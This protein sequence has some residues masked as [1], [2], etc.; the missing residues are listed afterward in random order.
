VHLSTST[1]DH[2][3][4]I[5]FFFLAAWAVSR[6]AG[7]LFGLRHALAVRR[8]GGDPGAADRVFRS[9]RQETAISLGQ[10]SVRYFAFLAAIAAAIVDLTPGRTVGAIAGASF[11]GL[12]IA[13]SAQRV[14]IDMIQGLFMF[15][16]RWYSVGD[17]IVVE[18]WNVEGVVEEVSLRQTTLRG[19][20]GE[21]MHVHNSQILAV[22]VVPSGLREFEIELYVKDPELGRRVIEHVSR[23]VPT[24]PTHFVHVP[25]L[26]ECEELADDLTRMTAHAAV[27]PGRE[28]LVE[29]FLVNL[30][31]ERASNGFLVHGPVVMS[32][33][34]T[35][36]RRFARIVSAREQARR[37]HLP[38]PRLGTRRG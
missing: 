36:T 22:R 10:T 6:A 17:T 29:D 34:E 35:A 31:K 3:A 4:R 26:R 12:M 13:F 9:K 19:V 18:P 14:L 16:E 33:D 8:G 15:F 32:V 24:G 1:L 23:L 7:L 30:I 28:W 37:P 25:E 20:N 27:P 2:A 11:A 38:L 21:L 5:G